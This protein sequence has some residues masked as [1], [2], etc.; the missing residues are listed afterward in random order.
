MQINRN[1]NDA[2]DTLRQ[3]L[4]QAIK[5]C[6]NEKKDLV[7]LKMKIQIKMIKKQLE[8]ISFFTNDGEY[9]TNEWLCMAYGYAINAIL[10]EVRNKCMINRLSK[11]STVE[12]L[13]QWCLGMG[14]DYDW[15]RSYLNRMFGLNETEADKIIDRVVVKE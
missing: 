5:F 3:R 9:N 8:F 7:V 11:Q 12:L 13:V 6:N 4:D 2:C 14:L 10:T 1:L 15:T